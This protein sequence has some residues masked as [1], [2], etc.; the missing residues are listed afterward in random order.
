MKSFN[1]KYTLTNPI[2]HDLT[3]ISESKAVIEHAKI[4]P[5]AEIRLRRLALVRMTQSSTA[6]EGNALNLRQVEDLVAGK[7]IEA[8]DRDIYE[9][10]NYLAA[11]KYIEKIVSKNQKF[12]Q[13]IF[14]QIHKLVTKNTLPKDKSGF[15]RLGPV[16]VVRHFLGLNQKVVYTAPP[17]HEV[18]TLVNNLINWLNQ[19][20]T[21][22]VNPIIVA[23]IVHQEIAAIHPF[24]DGNG[25]VA[26]AIS[27]LVLYQRG[28]GFRKLFALEDFY[29]LDRS[30]YY[31]AINTGEQYK[32]DKDLTSW[33]SYF[34]KGFKEEINNVKFKVQ[35]ISIKNLKGDLPQLFLDDDQRKIIDFI[36]QI[37][38]IT[39]NDVVDILNIPKRTAQ[40]KLLKLKKLKII[41]QIGK[42]PSSAYLIN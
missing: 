38:K 18:P 22:N 6:I 24:T 10:Q 40:L 5:T 32:K 7:K 15:F 4:L 33:L 3:I 11:L 28:Y 16:Y 27:T 14:L 9:V 36:D 30:K 35:Q 34:V 2:V 19:E 20:E 17:T 23:G 21:N 12:N 25:R 41:K 1:P 29:N 31:Q 37:G 26:R 8:P 42:G 39:T 13:K